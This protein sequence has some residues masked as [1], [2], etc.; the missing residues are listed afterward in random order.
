VF[1]GRKSDLCE[2][3]HLV[4]LLIEHVDGARRHYTVSRAA[5]EYV[6]PFGI[7]LSGR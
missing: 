2:I 7:D 6:A 1:A 4:G 3:D 5:K